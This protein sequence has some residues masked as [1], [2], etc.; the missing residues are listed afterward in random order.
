MHTLNFYVLLKYTQLK[1]YLYYTKK[2][3]QSYNNLVG[4]YL[5][6]MIICLQG[7]R[8]LSNNQC[9]VSYL[10]SSNQGIFIL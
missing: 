8:I 7:L 9:I 4:K 10:N 2:M 1:I 3:S 6:I 5:F